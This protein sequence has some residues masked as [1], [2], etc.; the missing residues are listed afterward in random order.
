MESSLEAIRYLAS[1][2]NRVEVLTA[3]ADG[4][5]TRRE[6]Q[7]D[8]NGSRSTVSRIL[9]EAQG[10][11]W[12]DSKGSRYWLTPLGQAMLGDFRSYLEAVEGLQHLGRTV[13]Q[14]PPPLQSL[15][16]RHLRDAVVVEPTEEDPAAPYTRAFDLFREATEY[17][18]LTHTALPDYSRVLRDGLEQDRIDFE[19]VL[20]R[21]FLETIRT[22]PRRA[23]VWRD[24]S[25]RVW[26]YDGVVPIN[27][28]V[29]DELV[30]VWLGEN[31]GEMA[32]LLLSENP[33]VVTWAESLYAGYRSESEPLGEL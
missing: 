1:S 17:R 9:D 15:D 6:L 32:G 25:D 11:G 7:E 21:A 19:H 33:A 10:Q 2:V 22:D 3:L 13:N 20:E 23:A 30:L 8:A 29:I 26:L 12:V 16:S 5:A 24:L 18:G 4:R 27:V 14:F 28:H 31:R